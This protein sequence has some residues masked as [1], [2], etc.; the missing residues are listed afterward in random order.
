MDVACIRVRMI[1]NDI[2]TQWEPEQYAYMMEQINS[3]NV[4]Q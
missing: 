2:F 3:S 1:W 4:D